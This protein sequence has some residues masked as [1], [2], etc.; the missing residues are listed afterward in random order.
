[1]KLCAYIE[2]AT[3]TLTE[4]TYSEILW[5]VLPGRYAGAWER[6]GVYDLTVDAPHYL[7]A[8]RSDIVV[9]RDECHVIPAGLDPDERG[10]AHSIEVL[11]GETLVGGIYG[12]CLGRA[13]CTDQTACIREW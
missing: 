13:D 1:M 10:F 8:Y 7:S 5:E 2:G 9:L 6:D 11:D 12:L 3:L 4:G